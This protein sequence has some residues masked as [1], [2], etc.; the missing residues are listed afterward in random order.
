MTQTVSDGVRLKSLIHSF[1]QDRLQAKLD[2]LP[3]DDPKRG[4]LIAQYEPEAWLADAARRVGQI[5]AVTHALKPIHPDARGTSLYVAP[6]Q[7]PTLGQVGSHVLTTGFASDV[8]GNAAA[9][10]VYKFLRLELDGRSIL[11]RLQCN[12]PA[13]RDAFSKDADQARQWADAFLGLVQDTGQAAASHVLAK[14]LY[15][16]TGS[17]S[18]DNGQYHLLAPLFPT[19]L[20]HA[21]HGV[22]QEDRFGD[23]AKLARQARR[24]QKLHDDAVRVYPDLAVR[25]LGGTKPQNISQ[26]NSE[27][28]GV[29]Y[30][31]SSLPP[32]WTSRAVPQPWGLN[33]V[34]DTLLMRRREVRHLTGNLLRFL[35]S[36]PASNMETRERVDRYISSLIDEVVSLAGE[37]RTAWPA[38]WSADSRC[39]MAREEQLW[40]DIGRV[41]EEDVFCSESDRQF[42]L[43]WQQM[44]WPEQIGHRFGNWLNARLHGHLP[45][46]EVEHRQWKKELLAYESSWMAQLQDLGVQVHTSISKGAV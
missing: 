44:Q 42:R 17:D 13:V 27:R 7:L 10:D 22:L 38:G 46:G 3:P 25:K 39:D 23:R 2:K 4:D 6:N 35:L 5:Q 21:V 12:E 34:F 40:L 31:L 26:L 1:I 19:S 30:L 9:L 16:L 45:V 18:S 37:L 24:E 28:G 36:K 8:V 33:S 29:N 41:E 14:Q 32:N 20:V 43:E 11:E 15:W